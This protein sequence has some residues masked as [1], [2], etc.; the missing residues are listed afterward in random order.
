[1]TRVQWQDSGKGPAPLTLHDA[2][3]LALEAGFVFPDSEGLP[4][5]R[6][7]N[8]QSKRFAH[9]GPRLWERSPRLL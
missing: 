9:R 5:V 7:A 2:Q 8:M 1:M 3:L 6:Q 4:L